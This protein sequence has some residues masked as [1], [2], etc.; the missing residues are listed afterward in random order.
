MDNRLRNATDEMLTVQR[1][2]FV[3]LVRYLDRSPDEALRAQAAGDLLG[4]SAKT[5]ARL[6][7]AGEVDRFDVS[8]TDNQ[9]DWRYSRESLEAFKSRR[10]G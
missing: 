1:A 9:A 5:L 2:W 8:T 3:E 10:S 7:A 4:V 6:A